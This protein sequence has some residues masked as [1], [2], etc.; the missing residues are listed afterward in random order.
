MI[1]HHDVGDDSKAEEALEFAHQCDKMFFLGVAEDETA[2]Y[3][4]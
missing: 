3:D 2:V 4:A 1:A